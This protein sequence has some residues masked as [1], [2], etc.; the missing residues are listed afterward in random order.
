MKWTSEELSVK[1]PNYNYSTEN[2][3]PLPCVAWQGVL[4]AVK[5]YLVCFGVED[6]NNRCAK[7]QCFSTGKGK[8]GDKNNKTGFTG[9]KSCHTNT[10]KS[11]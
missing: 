9:E 8:V 7:P 2:Q 6:V 1:M 10:V 11:S 5:L 3:K 4:L